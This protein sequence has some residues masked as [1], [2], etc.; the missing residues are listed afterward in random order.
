MQQYAVYT[1]FYCKIIVYVSGAVHTHH[2]EYT[3]LKLQP[4]VQ[5]ICSCSYLTPT[6]PTWPRW[7]EVA[8]QIIWLVPVAVI[9][10]LCTPD[11]GCGRQP[12]HVEWYSSKIKYRLHIVASRWTFINIHLH[13]FM[14]VYLEGNSR[15]TGS[16]NIRV[17]KK[18]CAGQVR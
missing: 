1:L 5:V 14:C 4:P 11:N 10:V 17:K 7:S 9:T 15:F 13:V 6:W 12:K 2:Q 3:K 18:N 16:I 8:A